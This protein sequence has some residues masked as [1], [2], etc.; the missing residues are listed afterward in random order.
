MILREANGKWW[1]RMIAKRDAR[2]RV[3]ER[4]D[5]GFYSSW[6]SFA[7]RDLYTPSKKECICELNQCG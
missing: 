6:G 7:A 5:G 4:M 2:D 1:E 3:S